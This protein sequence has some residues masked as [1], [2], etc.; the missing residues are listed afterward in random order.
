[1]ET[2]PRPAGPKPFP[3]PAP[4]LELGTRWGRGSRQG[5]DSLPAPQGAGTPFARAFGAG[6]KKWGYL[7]PPN[8]AF[9]HTDT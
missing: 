7:N 3:T 2:Y 5:E 1:M 4:D 6:E 9:W 8:P